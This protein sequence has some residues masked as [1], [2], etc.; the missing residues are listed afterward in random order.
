MRRCP[1]RLGASDGRSG[2][3]RRC[4]IR[5]KRRQ[6]GQAG[7]P[8]SIPFSAGGAAG[9]APSGNGG[10]GGTSPASGGG[11]GAN[12]ITASPIGGNGGNGGDSICFCADSG[13]AG[14]TGI[15]IT[16]SFA[17]VVQRGAQPGAGQQARQGER[18]IHLRSCEP[19]PSNGYVGL[20]LIGAIDASERAR[21]ARFRAPPD[22]N[23]DAA[24]I[25]PV[26]CFLRRVP[27]PSASSGSPDSK[28]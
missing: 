1:D 5:R 2:R 21:E 26:F 17:N 18:R 25:L 13:G 23:E 22:H 14:G 9:A 3:F 4:H 19:T 12:G 28:K 24:L 8:S 11:G 27:W 15:N 7:S 10:N 20:I 16:S 6:S